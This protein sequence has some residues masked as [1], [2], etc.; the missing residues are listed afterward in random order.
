MNPVAPSPPSIAGTREEWVTIGHERMRYLRSGSGLPMLL[1]HGL[2]G[3]SFS[4]RFNLASLAEFRE[5]FAPDLLGTGFS[6]R[7][8]NLDCRAETCARCLLQ[9]MD[10]AGADEFD[11]L[12]T[13]HGGGV[14][15]I[16]AAL[17]PERVRKLVL[18]APVN[19][20]SKH[21]QWITR[22]LATAAG[23]ATTKFLLPAITGMSHFWLARM[24]GNPNRIA[25]GTLAGYMAPF[26]IKGTFE[27]SL[28]IVRRWHQD[29]RELADAYSQISTETLLMW[30][31]KDPAV[32][33]SSANEI[34]KRL[35]KAQL[36]VFKG[37]GHLPYEEVPE[38]FNRALR[39]FL[40]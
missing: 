12:G 36:R 13:S 35:P 2:L 15:T 30:G 40:V 32:L 3:Y 31:D 33:I 37:V 6:D 17:A 38:E 21:G 39:N 7:A 34:L 1:I 23:R 29:L 26:K 4:W 9:F 11:L 10:G 20:W 19:P 8:A 14:A 28:D 24:Y 16:I 25:P 22:V 5:V 18:V 27:H